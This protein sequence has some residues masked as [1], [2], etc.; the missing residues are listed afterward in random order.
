VT[1]L[2]ELLFEIFGQ[3]FAV[4]KAAPNALFVV[5]AIVVAM[6]VMVRLGAG[7]V[8]LGLLRVLQ[9]KI[10]YAGVRRGGSLYLPHE[11]V[12]QTLIAGAFEIDDEEIPV[13]R[14]KLNAHIDVHGLVRL[15]VAL[16]DH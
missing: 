7:M 1:T 8:T 14:V 2:P 3:R 13:D 12:D 4:I 16:T 15:W 6:S 9:F 10:R 11:V 5:P